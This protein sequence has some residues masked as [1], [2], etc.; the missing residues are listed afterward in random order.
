MNPCVFDFLHLRWFQL[1][2]TQSSRGL[3]SSWK[4]L[5][6]DRLFFPP[7][8]DDD[9]FGFLDLPSCS[10]VAILIPAF[11]LGK[12]DTNKTRR[13]LTSENDNDWKFHYVNR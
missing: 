3:S 12:I 13:G 9:V 10:E 7:T 8:T 4:S 2:D 6:L 11:S 5:R 1:V